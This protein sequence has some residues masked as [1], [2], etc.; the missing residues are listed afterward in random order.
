MYLDKIDLSIWEVINQTKMCIRHFHM[1]LNIEYGYGN[2][3]GA[4]FSWS[5]Q[6]SL[7]YLCGRLV[8]PMHC[9]LQ[10][11]PPAAVLFVL[12]SSRCVHF[13][14]FPNTPFIQ[15]SGM[16]IRDLLKIWQNRYTY[17]METSKI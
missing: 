7:S 8:S 3:F 15:A 6:G 11:L 4:W 13:L 1:V 9:L 16:C 2:A 14:D 5:L 12:H 17:T 10:L